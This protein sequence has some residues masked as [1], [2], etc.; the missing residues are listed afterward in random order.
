[1]YLP[2]ILSNYSDEQVTI[3]GGEVSAIRDYGTA[4]WII[5]G[6]T[7]SSAAELTIDHTAS[8]LI[9]THHWIIRQNIIHGTVAFYGSYNLFEENEV[10]GS[11]YDGNGNAIWE[12]T[13]ISHHNV[14]RNNYL[15]DFSRRGIWSMKKTHDNEFSGNQISDME[16]MCIDLDGATSVVWRHNVSGNQIDGCGEEGIELEN[17]FETLVQNNVIRRTHGAVGVI[18]YG[19]DRHPDWEARCEVGGELNQYGDTDG[20]DDCEGDITNNIIRQNLIY[21][22]IGWEGGVIITHAGGVKIWG[23]TITMNNG[24]GIM[25]NSGMEFTPQIDIRGNIIFDN[26]D[27]EILGDLSSISAYENN[28]TSDPFFVNAA[29]NDYHLAPGSPAIDSGIYLGLLMDQ[30]GNPRPQGRG[31]DIGAFE[32]RAPWTWLVYGVFPTTLEVQ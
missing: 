31:Y 30:E 16:W 8:W 18:N 12:F 29:G 32:A 15:H 25:L 21:D 20:D 2:I 11:I 3:H 13:E 1:L 4:S 9:G 6:L 5:E 19:F 24:P 23:N 14:Y 26:T 7:L 28:F 17:A 27:G 22:G 10:S